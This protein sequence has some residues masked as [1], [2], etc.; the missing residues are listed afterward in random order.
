[1]TYDNDLL[2]A[3]YDFDNPPGADH[4]YFRNF[5]AEH[6]STT[7]VDYG[8]GTGSLTVTLAT[9]ERQVIGIDPAAAMLNVAQNRTGAE[10]VTWLQGQNERLA[11]L[12]FDT[13]LMTGNVAMHLIGPEWPETLNAIYS[14]LEP[15]GKIAFESRNPAAQ[16]WQ[17]WN[18]P[19]TTR[20]TPGGPITETTTTS[21]PDAHGI[22]HMH[23]SNHFSKQNLSVDVDV[24][25]Q[26]RSLTQIQE[27]LQK[28]GL[29]VDSV[30]STWDKQD[31][32]D[33]PDQPLMIIEA[34]RD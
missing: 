13:L 3:L 12:T 7:V 22:V 5:V 17:H 2:A 9:Q 20:D 1:M 27:D 29:T 32:T 24:A 30:W 19:K 33:S 10:S 6:G 21:P 15:G 26:F 14:S 28:S 25:L 8:C 34:T 16:E 4:D 11:A 23:C 18:H 31:F